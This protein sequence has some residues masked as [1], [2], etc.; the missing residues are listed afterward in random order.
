LYSFSQI[1]R[2]FHL[3]CDVGAAGSFSANAD[4][5][6]VIVSQQLLRDGRQQMWDWVVVH[7]KQAPDGTLSTR[8]LL[9]NP[10]WDEPLEIVNVE[11]RPEQ[12]VGLSKADPENEKA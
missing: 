12:N 7:S 2:P 5:V 11:S 1:E 4:R 9:C 6:S 8:V 3:R 10:D